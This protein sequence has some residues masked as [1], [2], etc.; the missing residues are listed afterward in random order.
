MKSEEDRYRCLGEE[1]LQA[2][3]SEIQQRMKKQ[4]NKVMNKS[5]RKDTLR[6]FPL[7]RISFVLE[8]HDQWFVN[9]LLLTS[10]SPPPSPIF[11]SNP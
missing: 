2:I 9:R 7:R 4:S 11:T 1:L 6:S 5:P 10:L 8:R 3:K